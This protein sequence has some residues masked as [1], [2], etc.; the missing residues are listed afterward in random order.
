MSDDL[1]SFDA[2]W[3]AYVLRHWQPSTRRLRLLRTSLGLAELA[4]RAVRDRPRREHLRWACAATLL[5]WGKLI[6]GTMDD[7]IE[8]LLAATELSGLPPRV[9]DVPAR[10]AAQTTSSAERSRQWAVWE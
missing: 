10:P 2:Y 9:V 4:L 6:A 1:H 7:E 8:R 3:S 5:T